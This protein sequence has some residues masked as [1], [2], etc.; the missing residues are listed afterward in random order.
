MYTVGDYL[1]DRLN[2]LGITE[3]FGVPGDYNLDFLDTIIAHD[4]L[5]WIGNANELN[6]A[7]MA[8]GYARTRH[9]AAFVTTFGVGELSAIN[10]LAGSFA[11]NVPVVEI[12]GSPTSEVQNSE[13]LVHHTLGDGIFTHF[14]QAHHSLTAAIAHLTAENAAGEIDRVLSVLL[15]T[16]RPVYINLPIDVAKAQIE[17]PSTP[18]SGQTN[19]TSPDEQLLETIQKAFLHAERPVVMTGHEI[20]SFGLEKKVQAFIEKKQTPCNHLKSW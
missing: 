16:R 13:K 9:A 15:E 2:E 6:A 4:Q 14:E 5:K 8:D 17:K 1:L 20:K 10:G 3:I 19:L 12:V 11:E 18:L 7:Y